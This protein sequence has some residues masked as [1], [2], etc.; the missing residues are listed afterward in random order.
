LICYHFFLLKTVEFVLFW[1]IHAL[2]IPCFPP[3]RQR[4]GFQLFQENQKARTKT[5]RRS[6]KNTKTRTKIR[7]RSIR[8]TSTVIKTAAKTRT[9]TRIGTKRKIKAD[10]VIPVLITQRNTMKRL[11]NFRWLHLHCVDIDSKNCSKSACMTLQFNSNDEVV[12][13]CF[14]I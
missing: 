4:K 5:R 12:L 3:N 9:R 10:I 2:I 6:I 13:N 14:V 8:S 11:R 1:H 7:I